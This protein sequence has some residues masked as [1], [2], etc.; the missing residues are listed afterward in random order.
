MSFYLRY[1]NVLFHLLF[2]LKK[3]KNEITNFLK[4]RH[5]ILLRDK[6]LGETL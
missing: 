2:F 3:T 5:K 6:L 4:L 1:H